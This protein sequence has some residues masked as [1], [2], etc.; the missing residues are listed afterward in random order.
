MAQQSGSPDGFFHHELSADSD[1]HVLG[2]RE[3]L[4]AHPSGRHLIVDLSLS[5]KRQAA[6][7]GNQAQSTVGQPS[8]RMLEGSH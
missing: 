1:H 6:P 5:W 7:K 4:R 3:P 2:F 8:P